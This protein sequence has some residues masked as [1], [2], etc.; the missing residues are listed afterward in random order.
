MTYR[1]QGEAIPDGEPLDPGPAQKCKACGTARSTELDRWY[2]PL[3]IKALTVPSACSPGAR[4]WVGLFHRC[5]VP[6]SHLHEE[7]RACGHRW[8]TAFAGESQDHMPPLGGSGAKPPR[9]SGI[10]PPAGST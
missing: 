8:L 1:T 3:L 10:V 9:G 2:S 5:K 4:V 6:G 7:C